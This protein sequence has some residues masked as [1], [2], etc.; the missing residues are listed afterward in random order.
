M[1]RTRRHVKVPTQSPDNNENEYYNDEELAHCGGNDNHDL[2][3]A[4]TDGIGHSEGT[5][6][7]PTQDEEDEAKGG[8]GNDDSTTDI[9]VVAAES[10]VSHDLPTVEEYKNKRILDEAATVASSSSSSS[11]SSTSKAYRQCR[12]RWLGMLWK[13]ALFLVALASFIFVAMAVIGVVDGT[14]W[15]SFLNR[16]NTNSTNSTNALGSSANDQEVSSSPRIARLDQLIYL[17]VEQE[18]WTEAS[19]L[20]DRKGP[21]WDACIW[22][23]EYDR[24][25]L[26]FSLNNTNGNN[27]TATMSKLREIKERYAAAVFY[28]ALNGREWNY[29]M[30]WLS[31]AHICEWGLSVGNS[32]SEPIRIGLDCPCFNN[33]DSSSSSTFCDNNSNTTVQRV[34]L[35][36]M[37]LDGTFPPEIRLWENLVELDLNHNQ[38]KGEIPVGVRSLPAL[39]VL[40]LHSNQLEG[41]LPKWIGKMSNLRTL[42]LSNNILTGPIPLHMQGLSDT[43]QQLTLSENIFLPSAD[44]LHLLSKLNNLRLLL[45]A[46]IGLT[47][48][49][50]DPQFWTDEIWPHMQVLDLGQNQLVGSLPDSLF[51]HSSLAVLDLRD[52][53]L[54]GFIPDAA[55]D[56][57]TPS[58]TP[59]QYLSLQGNNLTGTFPQSWISHAQSLY[60]IDVSHN[61]LTG[62]FPVQLP[63]NQLQYIDLS[64][65]DFDPGAIPQNF[66]VMADVAEDDASFSS[67]NAALKHLALQSTNRQG[68]IANMFA[69][70][71]NGDASLQSNWWAKLETLDLGDN[72]LAGPVPLAFTGA[73]GMERVILYRNQF[74]GDFA[75]IMTHFHHLETLVVHDNSWTAGIQVASLCLPNMKEFIMDN[76]V[77]HESNTQGNDTTVTNKHDV[78][79][80]STS[81]CPCCQCCDTVPGSN[82][83][84]VCRYTTTHSVA[85]MDPVWETDYVRK[86]FRVRENDLT[87]M[88][89]TS[90]VS[91]GIG[92][93]S[94]T[95]D[96][97]GD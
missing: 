24:R 51:F 20:E 25:N 70:A 59:L 39:Q 5:V 49:L 89:T 38:I 19:A 21:Q 55:P 2:R 53:R 78:P 35:P 12:D 50:T 46:N 44:D 47:G 67:S 69:S 72:D 71:V 41:P 43:L 13:Y 96:N 34:V 29:D 48:T 26:D 63:Q 90:A 95:S 7:I 74:T 6:C 65:N 11:S 66:L 76:C 56:D 22:L 68:S 79:S 40:A 16:Y 45:A 42:K 4:C 64:F 73:T 54:T 62:P 17:V 33:T 30:F 93:D 10:N 18:R 57:S 52:N 28:F 15:L 8:N 81:Y 77:R 36:S 32:N 82:T 60:H 75:Q 94:G 86:Q 80:A 23:A 88:V 85:N 97:I 3:E 27:N 87:V 83:S 1:L 14:S 84:S 91:T 58:I 37:G 31:E 9:V 92:L 61:E